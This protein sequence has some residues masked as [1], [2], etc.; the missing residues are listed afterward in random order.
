MKL[1][2]ISLTALIAFSTF[3]IASCNK[4]ELINLVYGST[5]DSLKEIDYTALST[6]VND[7]DSFIL[8]ITSSSLGCGCWST[9]KNQVLTPYQIQNKVLIYYINHNEFYDSNHKLLDTFGFTITQDPGFGLFDKGELKYEEKYSSKNY[10][11]SKSDYFVEYM[12]SKV[13][14]PHILYISQEQLE[15]KYSG[16]EP[17]TLMFSRNNCGDC[18]YVLNNFFPNYSLNLNDGNDYLYIFECED[19]VVKV[20]NT[21]YKVREYDEDGQLTE[22]SKI[23]WQQFKD[24]YGLSTTNNPIY[25]YNSGYVPTLFRIEPNGVDKNGNVIKDGAVYFNDTISKEGN[26]YV[27]S[28]SYYT[29]ERKEHLSYLSE[30]DIP[31]L[32][33]LEISETDV[34]SYGEYVSWN[35]DAA[36]KYHSK[37]TKA[38]LDKYL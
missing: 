11:F 14:L 5:Y 25:G 19:A 23:R 15:Q 27:V 4:N 33:G 12:S 37:L 18:K 34:T 24:D 28:D 36:E 8:A 35:H 26:K 38:F 21:Y 20:G 1:K 30:I 32:K 6:M 7:G 16:S 22:E 10:V 31:V 2:N 13:K 3:T 29:N 17:F 9:F